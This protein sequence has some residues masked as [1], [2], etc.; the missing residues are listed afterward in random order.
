MSNYFFFFLNNYATYIS[1]FFFHTRRLIK[2]KCGCI[3]RAKSPDALHLKPSTETCNSWNDVLVPLDDSLD[4]LANLLG[5]TVNWKWVFLSL[6]SVFNRIFRNKSWHLRFKTF[7]MYPVFHVVN[8]KNKI[9]FFYV[10]LD[11]R[12]KP[13]RQI[14]QHWRRVKPKVSADPQ[15]LL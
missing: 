1:P 10:L 6:V 15:Y 3:C 2:L 5:E 13:Q 8:T 9:P 7:Y 4:T 14:S 11:W 12:Q